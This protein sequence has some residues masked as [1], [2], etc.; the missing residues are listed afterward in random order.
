[1]QPMRI[2]HAPE[3][4]GGNPYGLARAEREIGLASWAVALQ[5][6]PFRHPIDEVLCPPGSPLIRREI[7]RWALL[8]R[9]IWEFDVIHFNFGASLLP[10]WVPPVGPPRQ[11]WGALPRYAYGWYA[12]LLELRDLPLLQRAGKGIVVT[13]QGDDA[14]QGDYC[15]RHYAISPATEVEPGYYS[16]GSDAR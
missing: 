7:Q 14:R 9:A 2:L 3:T 4:V 11:P 13:Y 5:E 15:R 12:R 6:S 8:R 10:Q 16:A 1:M